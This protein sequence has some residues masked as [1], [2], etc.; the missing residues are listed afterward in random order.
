M[1]ESPPE[2]AAG[3]SRP[4]AVLCADGAAVRVPPRPQGAA[5]PWVLPRCSVQNLSR[6]FSRSKS[7]GKDPSVALMRPSDAPDGT[8]KVMFVPVFVPICDPWW[9]RGRRDARFVLPDQPGAILWQATRLKRMASGAAGGP[10]AGLALT[11]RGLSS[12]SPSWS[13]ALWRT[14]TGADP[15]ASVRVPPGERVKIVTCHVRTGR[16]Q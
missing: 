9:A 12:A 14:E 11:S 5:Q 1:L 7:R 4:R 3:E 16:S 6:P 15:S 2:H 10:K 13:P 8:I